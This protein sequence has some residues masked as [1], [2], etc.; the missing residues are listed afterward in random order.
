MCT[1]KYQYLCW[2][3]FITCVLIS[4]YEHLYQAQQWV[5]NFLRNITKYVQLSVFPLGWSC[6]SGGLIHAIRFRCICIVRSKVHLQFDE[7]VFLTNL[8]IITCR[9]V[10]LTSTLEGTTAWIPD[11]VIRNRAVKNTVTPIFQAAIIF[12]LA[13]P[14]LSQPF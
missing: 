1:V 13:C 14:P 5:F 9:G 10:N 6:S 8:R 12:S 11:L 3:V 7:P 4:P 2:S